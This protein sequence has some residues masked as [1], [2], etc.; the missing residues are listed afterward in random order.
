MPTAAGLAYSHFLIDGVPYVGT[1]R[2]DNE[3]QYASGEVA[4]PDLSWSCVDESGHFHA[5]DS[6]SRE[7]PTFAARSVRM[8]CNG[9]CGDSENCDGYDGIR[10]HCLIC[11]EQIEPRFVK[12][13]QEQV[14]ARTYGWEASVRGESAP[15]YGA[16][17]SVRITSATQAPRF[18]VAR[19]TAWTLSS[20]GAEV[21]LSGIGRLGYRPAEDRKEA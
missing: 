14:V 19:V 11:D 13:I 4:E 8:P 18:G 6:M 17:V 10:Y 1:Y 16:L 3:T 21:E 5:F 2:L 9:G 20:D 15:K 12:S 7:H